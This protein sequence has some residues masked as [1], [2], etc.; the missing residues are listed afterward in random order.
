VEKRLGNDKFP[1][2]IKNKEAVVG[3]ND[4]KLFLDGEKKKGIK[5]LAKWVLILFVTTLMIIGG[6]FLIFN[7][8][9]S[10]AM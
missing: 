8:I 3:E 6:I 5:N 10:I 1:H 2:R 4:L 7:S 9:N